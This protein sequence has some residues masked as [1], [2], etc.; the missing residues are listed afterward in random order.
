MRSN[1]STRTS[2]QESEADSEFERTLAYWD[3]DEEDEG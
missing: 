2:E 3:D 1:A